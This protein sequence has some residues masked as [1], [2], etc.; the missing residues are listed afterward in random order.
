MF[1]YLA[2]GP[3][4]VVDEGG[5]TEPELGAVL[6]TREHD[7]EVVGARFQHRA[8]LLLRQLGDAPHQLLYLR[9]LVPGNKN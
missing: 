4:V 7:A 5:R 8:L 6:A 3:T 2:V 1:A 9:I